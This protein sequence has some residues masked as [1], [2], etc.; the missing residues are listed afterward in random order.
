MLRSPALAT[1]CENFNQTLRRIGLRDLL[2]F[3][4]HSEWVIRTIEQTM[5]RC[6]PGWKG[7][8]G[9]EQKNGTCS[10]QIDFPS[11]SRD[12]VRISTA[13]RRIWSNLLLDS[14]RY[15]IMHV[16]NRMLH[17][18]I[19]AADKFISSRRITARYVLEIRKCAFIR[20]I[21]RH[22]STDRL[23]HWVGLASPTYSGMEKDEIGYTSCG[24]D[25]SVHWTD[26]NYMI[27]MDFDCGCSLNFPRYYCFNE[28][29][30]HQEPKAKSFAGLENEHPL[31]PI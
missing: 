27:D 20:W 8:R 12:G 21:L 24:A 19:A 29:Q 18:H 6:W 30:L 26:F 23:T 15:R 7:N 9:R 4:R 25:L 22:K 3:Y 14:I 2:S 16:F 13:L 31:S 1:Y 11:K 17:A 10:I 28:L 5:G